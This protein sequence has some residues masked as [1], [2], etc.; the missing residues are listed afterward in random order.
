[1]GAIYIGWC[2]FMILRKDMDKKNIWFIILIVALTIPLM[3]IDSSDDDEETP[4]TASR[5]LQG[6]QVKEVKRRKVGRIAP[7]RVINRE[8]GQVPESI[9][10]LFDLESYQERL[11]FVFRLSDGL[12]AVERDALYIFLRSHENDSGY[13]HVKD[14]IMCR[15]ERQTTRPVEYERALYSIMKDDTIDGDLRGYA[16]QHLRS[17]YAVEGTD[18][19]LIKEALFQALE[20]D[21][22]DVSGT[23]M[24]AFAQMD[25]GLLADEREKE[26]VKAR[27]LELAADE[28]VHT[29]SR[30]TI[31]ECC[32]RM[33]CKE[34]IPI[35]KEVIADD[36]KTFADKLPAIASIGHVGDESHIALLEELSKNNRLKPAA[37]A[38]ITRIKK[39]LNL[40]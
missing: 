22:S 31:I 4:R 3:L 24:L 16:V 34:I 23:A 38:A 40:D 37:T 21:Q 30:N 18:K 36:S 35:A 8:L 9:R 17:A 13:L 20:D 1:M 11:D 26:F 12:N 19:S 33:G 27:A 6:R 29:P 10:P 5:P 15:L 2:P 14:E 39:R 28:S 7:Y 32:G 25:N